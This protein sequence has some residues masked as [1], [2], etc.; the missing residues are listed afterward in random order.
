[1]TQ[2]YYPQGHGKRLDA[3]LRQLF[4]HVY[5]LQDKAGA[6]SAPSPTKPST[7]PDAGSPSHTKIAGLNVRAI[8]PTNG[9]S[10]ATLSK[11][12]VLGY[13]SKSGEIT[14]F[15]PT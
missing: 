11:I 3:D 12:P 15:I 8:Q 1:M 9:A 2:K 6:A 13:D 4:D 7:A 10:V 5:K 14:W